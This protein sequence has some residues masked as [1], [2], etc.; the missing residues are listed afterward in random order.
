MR[1]KQQRRV[2]TQVEVD[3][4]LYS[5]CLDHIIHKNNRLAHKAKIAVC[6]NARAMP[7]INLYPVVH[8]SFSLHVIKNMGGGAL[9]QVDPASVADY[10]VQTRKQ[11]I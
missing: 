3:L 7:G 11:P 5:V 1:F 4:S 6:Y 10:K 9:S 8:A 2:H